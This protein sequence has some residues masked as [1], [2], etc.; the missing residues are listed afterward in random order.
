MKKLGDPQVKQP[1]GP[2]TLEYHLSR[3]RLQWLVAGRAS[4]TLDAEAVTPSELGWVRS[5][6]KMVPM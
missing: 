6:W 4:G 5:Q 2:G 1:G 3:K